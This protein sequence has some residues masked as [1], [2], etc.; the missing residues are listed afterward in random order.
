[1]VC[2]YIYI[3]ID[4]LSFWTDD[5]LLFHYVSFSIISVI[6]RQ[7]RENTRVVQKVLSLI[8]FLSF[9]PGIL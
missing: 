1:M 4:T 9:L 3:Y 5:N 8:G 2:V 6:S 7:G